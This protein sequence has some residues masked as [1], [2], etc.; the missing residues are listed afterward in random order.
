MLSV[1]FLNN[2]HPEDTYLSCIYAKFAL[3]NIDVRFDIIQIS[4][5]NANMP[6]FDWGVEKM[7]AIHSIIEDWAKVESMN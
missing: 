7:N 3:W 1:M 4:N 2:K 6:L 5:S